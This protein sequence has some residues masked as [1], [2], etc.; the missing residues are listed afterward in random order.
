MMGTGPSGMPGF[1]QPQQ[2]AATSQGFGIGPGGPSPGGMNPAP[3]APLAP[4]PAAQPLQIPQG[5][6]SPQPGFPQGGPVGQAPG[7]QI[8]IA[9]LM[10]A[11]QS[12][13]GGMSAGQGM[14]MGGPAPSSLFG[15]PGAIQQR[16]G[17]QLP[18]NNALTGVQGTSPL[19][20]LFRG[21]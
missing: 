21:L 17:V 19:S 1:L 9:A 11:L 14:P 8:N 3:Q 4:A 13:H 2:P 15:N 20:A 6:P 16:P 18:Q 7:Q 12:L 5:M 10:Q